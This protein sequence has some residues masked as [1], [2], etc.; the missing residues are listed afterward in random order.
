MIA[1]LMGP[2]GKGLG[3]ALMLAALATG[4]KVWL[5]G[6]DRAVLSGYV[7]LSE[8]TA[9]DARAAEIA[10]QAD[11]AAQALKTANTEIAD[12][13]ARQ[14]QASAE[15]EKGIAQYEQRLLEA[16]RACLLDDRDLQFFGVMHH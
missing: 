2:L 5:V 3:A 15:L 14:A 10:R 13:K 7:T 9:A 16:K 1:L 4:F 12:A 11:A 6:H 8:K